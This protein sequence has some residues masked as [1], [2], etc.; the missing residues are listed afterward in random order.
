VV[1]V[2]EANSKLYRGAS[3]TATPTYLGSFTETMTV[4]SADG[5]ALLVDAIAGGKVSIWVEMV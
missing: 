4:E 2:F 3:V 5:F 1:P